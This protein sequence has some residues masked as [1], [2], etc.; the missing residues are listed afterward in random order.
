MTPRARVA[1]RRHRPP[2]AGA[3]GEE[4]RARSADGRRDRSR[5][6]VAGGG[7]RHARRDHRCGRRGLLR[8][9]GSRGARG[10]DRCRPRGAARR[11]AGPWPGVHV[12]P[13]SCAIPVIAAVRGR[14]LAGGAGLATAC[15][16]VLAHPDATFGYPEVRIGF[17]PAMVMTILRRILPERHA[18]DLAITG[19]TLTAPE[20]ER[21]GLVSRITPADAFD[22]TVAELAR[23]NREVAGRSGPSHEEA[24]LRARR[25]PVRER[26]RARRAGECGR[27][28]DRRVS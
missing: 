26:H 1:D 18:F 6:R 17:V 9:R 12:H 15:D 7:I 14:A 25:P 23:G 22:A 19:R 3:P 8:G 16:M 24:L 10:A 27:E 20:A 21:L 5:P 2:H 28:N 4:E 13:R 11:R